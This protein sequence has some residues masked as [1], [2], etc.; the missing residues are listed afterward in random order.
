MAETKKT[1]EPKKA[2]AN[3]FS[4][5]TPTRPAL[6]G[7][8]ARGR[9]RPPS[10]RSRLQPEARAEVSHGSL[11]MRRSTSRNPSGWPMPTR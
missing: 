8:T 7:G 4:H 11:L 3:R 6:R 5:L 10:S 1:P 9:P 2:A